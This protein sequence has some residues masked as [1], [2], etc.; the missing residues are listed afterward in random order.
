MDPNAVPDPT[1]RAGRVIDFVETLTLWEG[2]RAGQ[3]LKLEPYQ[4]YIV[5]RIY[6]PMD[7][8]GQPLVKTAAVWLP[9][10][11]TKT[12]LGAALSLAHFI[13]PEAESG[14]QV[15]FAAADRE[16]AG[17]AY[18]H[19]HNFVDGDEIYQNIVEKVASR[20]ELRYPAARAILRA[21]SSE[22]YSKHGMSVTF[23]LADEIHAWP[24]VTARPLWDAITDSMIKRRH[25]LTVIISTAGEGDAGLAREMWDYSHAV[26]DGSI[27]DPSWCSIICGADRNADW[28][29]EAV[30]RECNP[31]LAAGII[32]LDVIRQRAARAQLSIADQTSFKRYYLNLWQ[33][34][35][36]E[37]WIDIAHWDRQ[38]QGLSDAEFRESPA[39]MGVDLSAVDDLT[40]VAIVTQGETE[41][42]ERVW[43]LRGHFWL[44]KDTIHDKSVQDRAN[45]LE[46][47]RSGWLTLTDGNV[48]DYA[49]IERYIGDVWQ[50]HW[51][52]EVGID[53]WNATGITTRLAD[54]GIEMT[55]VGQAIGSIS[56]SVKEL[57]RAVIAGHLRHDGNLVMRYCF[58]NAVAV[59]D[60][61]ENMKLAKQ[62]N[63]RRRIDGAVAAAI[64]IKMALAAD[65]PRDPNWWEDIAFV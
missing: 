14:G 27:S 4:R 41:S 56:A 5:K 29:D 10:G 16:N 9:R 42:G 63:R 3:P 6:G 48:V 51:I 31:G 7:E 11:N 26:A 35:A 40:S 61:N 17:I 50:T 20:K 53:P 44:P 38:P 1:G 62:L 59:T 25:A 2:A 36:A 57:T 12:T 28:Q 64:A 24:E 21:L 58:A 23:F 49:A 60:A 15:A 32:N 65:A 19:A 18:R 45:Y 37:P 39:Y 47:S 34:G 30:W 55:L 13:G 33:E 8:W 52:E 46:W 22:A 54:Q 43:D